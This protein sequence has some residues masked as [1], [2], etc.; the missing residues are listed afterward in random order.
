MEMARD[1]RKF[2]WAYTGLIL[3]FVYLPLVVIIFL[4]F[5]NTASIGLPFIGFSLQWYYQ[6]SILANGLGGFLAD[7]GAIS[8]LQ[9]SVTVGLIVAVMSTFITVASVLVLRRG[10]RGRSCFF[11]FLV[12]ALLVRE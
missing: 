8:A 9:N 4:S 6:P 10:F 12:F 1:S 5:N 3:A 7:T 11:F 2:F